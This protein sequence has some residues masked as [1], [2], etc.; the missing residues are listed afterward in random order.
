MRALMQAVH[1]VVLIG[2]GPAAVGALLGLPS[3]LRV[4]IATG[5]A[6]AHEGNSRSHEIHP[7][8]R[9]VGRARNELPGVAESLPFNS[10]EGGALFDTATIGG[11]ANYW[12]QQF[13]RYERCD[14]WPREFF[15]SYADYISACRDVEALFSCSPG[16]GARNEHV[17]DAGYVGRTPNLL[18]GSAKNSGDGLLAMREVFEQLAMARRAQVSSAHAIGWEADGECVHLYLSDGNVLTGRYLLLACGAVGSLR[19]T[20][21]ACP[22]VVAVSMRDHAPWMVYGAGV[23][24]KLNVGR[25]DGLAH[26]NDLTVEFVESERVRLFASVYRMS[27]APLGLILAALGLRPLFATI[28]SPSFVD[29]VTPIQIWTDET[30]M[31]YRICKGQ[32]RATILERPKCN[33]DD[34]FREFRNWL[35]RDGVIL[36]VSETRPGAGFHYHA[37]EVSLDGMSFRSLSK[38]LNERFAGRV[39]GLD[40]SVLSTIGCR[41]H[42]LTAMTAALSIANGLSVN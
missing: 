32:K 26:F 41:P 7:K 36:R 17:F 9:A 40:A 14:P 15:A 28:P 1:D 5:G 21:E 33:R 22:E 4:A 12:G 35:G 2:A 13:I 38:F 11:L 37:G 31:M 30:Y 42:T 23:R 25:V 27:K 18:I 24:H 19:L 20:M 34:R 6:R 8:I 3:G 10:H 39:V 16:G 29:V